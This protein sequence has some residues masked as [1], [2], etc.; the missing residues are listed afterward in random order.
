MTMRIRTLGIWALAAAL[1]L[2]AARTNVEAQRGGRGAAVRTP[3]ASALVDLTG[4]WVSVV[5]EDWRC[6]W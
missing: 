5:S 6:A 4:T 2:T 1:G 3:R